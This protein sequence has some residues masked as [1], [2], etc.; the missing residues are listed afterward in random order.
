MNQF[1]SIKMWL[2]KKNKKIINQF[3]YVTFNF[4]EDFYICLWEFFF[5][6]TTGEPGREGKEK[7][8]S[9]KKKSADKRALNK[10]S[11]QH[12][13]S[14]TQKSALVCFHLKST[15]YFLI[16]V[17]PALVIT[18]TAYKRNSQSINHQR[19]NWEKGKE[20]THTQRAIH[21]RSRSS[22]VRVSFSFF[23]LWSTSVLGFYF[24]P[25]SQL[26]FCQICKL[27]LKSLSFFFF[28][29]SFLLIFQ[30]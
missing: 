8:K 11:S 27:L 12:L 1:V 21:L 17:W 3:W 30:F 22:Q 10:V 7:Q 13:S 29:Y 15:L 14:Q 6:F 19:T 4:I 16:P 20:K 9:V 2:N 23:V 28:G 18:E 26:G 25:K 24:M 5:L